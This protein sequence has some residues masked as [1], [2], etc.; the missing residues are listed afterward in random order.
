MKIAGRSLKIQRIKIKRRNKETPQFSAAC[1]CLV[2]PDEGEALLET[3]SEN[4]TSMF[5]MRAVPLED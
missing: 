4:D 3:Q 2:Q 5:S 1:N